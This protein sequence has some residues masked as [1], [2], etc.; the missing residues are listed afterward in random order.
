MLCQRPRRYGVVVAY[1]LFGDILTDLGA[2]I[3]GGMV[4]AGA[5]LNPERRF[6][7]STSRSTAPP[8]TSPERGGKPSGVHWAASQM[9]D[10][11]GLEDWGAAV[12]DLS[13][14][15]GGRRG[16]DAR[17]GGTATTAQV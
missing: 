12:L 1:N 16:A 2:A 4:A 3:A 9:L 17:S 13:N 8:R 10:F 11:F 6:P 7:S 14:R 5:N 15:C